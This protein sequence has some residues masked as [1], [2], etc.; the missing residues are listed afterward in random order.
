MKFLVKLSL[1]APEEIGLNLPEMIPNVSE[2]MHD[3]KPEVSKA[4]ISCM[5]QLCK[6]VGNPDMDPHIELLVDCMAHPDHVSTTG[7]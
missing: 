3:T 5:S 1:K 7:L 4:A 2:C 6:V